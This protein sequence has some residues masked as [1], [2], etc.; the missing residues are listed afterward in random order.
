MVLRPR[1]Q[2]PALQLD[3][4]VGQDPAT[5]PRNAVAEDGS[6]TATCCRAARHRQTST[7]RVLARPR[8]RA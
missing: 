4:I 5:T 1:A 6:P 2:I 3:E 8:L 7:A